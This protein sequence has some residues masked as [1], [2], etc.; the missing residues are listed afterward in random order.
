MRGNSLL[1]AAACA[2]PWWLGCVQPDLEAGSSLAA[3]D[4]DYFRCEVEPVLVKRCA[5]GACHGS[6]RR[7]FRIY[8]PSRLRVGAANTASLTE[9]EHQANFDM[10]RGFASD[11]DGEP[12][13]ELKP[14][15]TEAGGYFHRGAEIFAGGDSFASTEDHGY[16]VIVDWARDGATAPSDCTPAEEMGP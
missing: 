11:V 15:S 7:P 14:L 1:V 3:L 2:L 13:L 16:Q 10:A 12:L 4:S 5:F 6:E 8:A 9:D